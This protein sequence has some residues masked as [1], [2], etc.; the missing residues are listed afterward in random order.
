[1]K[2]VLRYFIIEYFDEKWINVLFFFQI[3]MNNFINFATEIVFNEFTIDFKI[4]NSLNMLFNLFP[5]NYALFRNVKRSE[6]HE[7]ITFINAKIKIRY[8]NKYKLV[9]MC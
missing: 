6:I 2:I 7:I 1:M 5:E 4:R 9:N 3:N 8:D